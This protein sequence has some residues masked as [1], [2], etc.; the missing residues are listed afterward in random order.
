MRIILTIAGLSAEFGGP[1]RSV[2]ALAAALGRLGADVELITTMPMASEGTPILPPSH[3]VRSHLLP[4]AS[5]S[6]RWL[7]G[8]N[9][10][11]N[12]VREVCSGQADAVIHDQGVWLPSN[13]AVAVA[14][15][16][17]GRPRVVS[18][19]GMMSSWA[20][21][22]KGVKKK[23]AWS[24]YQRRDLMRASALHVTSRS[25]VDD[26]RRSG[27]AGPVTVVPNGTDFP[28][29]GFD[30]GRASQAAGGSP[31]RTA[32]CLSRVHPVK[33]LSTLVEAW[34]QV[35]PIGWRLVIG[36]RNESG[37]AAE[38]D[39]QIAAHGLRDSVEMIGEVEGQD[40][41]ALYGSA[42]LFVLPSLSENFGIVVAEALAS[43]V[44]VVTTRATPWSE[45]ATRECGWWIETGL[46][47]LTDTLRTAL[48]TPSAQLRAMGQRGRQLVESKYTWDG[49]AREMLSFYESV[50]REH[51]DGRTQ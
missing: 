37:H 2:P 31:T 28:P 32:L 6:T 9:A 3:L 40:K 18:P 48:S 17:L 45:L 47:S 16:E 30:T 10:F 46:V 7:S 43:G 36:G 33:G 50:V 27:Y 35:R 38:L 26:C 4:R 22:A 11:A 19:R 12:T 42:D 1:S 49:A 8:S 14:A 39:R 29:A 13:H 24:L 41:W 44:P 5:R 21:A 15:Q 20:L 25:E 23:I 51:K 34:A